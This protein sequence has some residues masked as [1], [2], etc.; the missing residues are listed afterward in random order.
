MKQLAVA[1]CIGRRGGGVREAEAHS[2]GTWVAALTVER[3]RVNERRRV[4]PP[5]L[6]LPLAGL[7]LFL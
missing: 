3:R 4:G 6:G 7:A 2:F 5:D 1:H